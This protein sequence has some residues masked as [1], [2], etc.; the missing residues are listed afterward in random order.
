MSITTGHVNGQILTRT[1]RACLAYVTQHDGKILRSPG[2]FWGDRGAT[3]FWT[4][5]VEA[6]VTRGLLHY[7]GWH[8]GATR[9]PIEAMLTNIDEYSETCICEIDKHDFNCPVHNDFAPESRKH[10]E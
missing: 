6:L 3:W 8:E 4:T 9:F 10:H 5:T 1:M 2:G 7:S